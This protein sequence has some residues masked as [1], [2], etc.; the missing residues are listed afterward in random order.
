MDGVE[1]FQPR[2]SG[3]AQLRGPRSWR[4]TLT[5]QCLVGTTSYESSTRGHGERSPSWWFKVTLFGMV[6]TKWPLVPGWSRDLQ[7]S[8][9]EV[10]SLCLNHLVEVLFPGNQLD[11]WMGNS[12]MFLFEFSPRLFG[13]ELRAVSDVT[14]AYVFFYF[15]TIQLQ[16]TTTNHHPT[17][18]NNH[19]PPSIKNYQIPPVGH[20][21]PT[22]VA[23]KTPGHEKV[24]AFGAGESCD[25]RF[26]LGRATWKHQS[27]WTL[28]W[29]L[30]FHGWS[31][32]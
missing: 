3:L 2:S 7:W 18:A 19:Q 12:K 32:G 10:W 16:P 5:S 8:G 1:D 9:D 21:P 27:L 4:F 11:K 28:G 13:R 6:N 22:F 31:S 23:H 14:C 25:G 20:E 29:W 30:K 15:T 17:T 24:D 26:F